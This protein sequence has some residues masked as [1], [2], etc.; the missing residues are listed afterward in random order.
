MTNLPTI[1]HLIDDTTPGGVTRVLEHIRTCKIMAKTAIH[2]VVAVPKNSALPAVTG[3]IIVSHRTINWRNL[4]GLI[5]FRARHSATPLIHVEHSYTA[6]F[7]SLNVENKPRFFT[8]LRTA[9]ALF[10]NVVAVSHAQGRWMAQRNLVSKETLSIIPSVVDLSA[11]DT[12][13]A[14]AGTPRV[15]GAIGRLHTQK[16]FDVLIAAFRQMR[17]SDLR[18]KIFGTGPEETALKAAA[19]TDSRIEFCGH[20]ETPELAMSQVDLVAMPSRWEAFG[21]VALE[22]QA[23]GRPLVCADRDGLRDSAG[24]SATFVAGHATAAWRDAL[25]AAISNEPSVAPRHPI[26]A[27]ESFA[28]SWQNLT[29]RHLTKNA[30]SELVL[31]D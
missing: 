24:S 19:K 5:A 22:A 14:P 18:L 29:I 15:I 25:T 4:P 12:L 1:T 3:D 27:V 9:Y 31:N 6:G 8:L 13:P 2:D 10:D 23:A 20:A 7:T 21:L 11:F 26:A 28:Q 30:S 17:G 16:G